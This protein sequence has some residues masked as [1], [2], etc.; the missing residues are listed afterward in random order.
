MTRR[1]VY[2]NITDVMNDDKINPCD[3]G[4]RALPGIMGVLESCIIR[5]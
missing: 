5:K 1:L 4:K 2:T 3:V